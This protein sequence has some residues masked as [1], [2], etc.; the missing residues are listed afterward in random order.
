MEMP[1][2]TQRSSGYL[3]M[4]AVR[5]ND[6]PHAVEKQQVPFVVTD[7]GKGDCVFQDLKGEGEGS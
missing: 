4:T 1:I 3:I 2:Q 6:A 7:E 5:M